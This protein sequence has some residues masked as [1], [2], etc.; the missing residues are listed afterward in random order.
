M[1]TVSVTNLR[2]DIRKFLR[3]VTRE[4][5]VVRVTRYGR[6]VATIV[7]TRRVHS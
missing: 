1:K 2:K 6:V 4:R 3:L 5:E 7:P